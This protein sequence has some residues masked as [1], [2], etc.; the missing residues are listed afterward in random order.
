LSKDRW[1]RPG[2]YSSAGQKRDESGV[3]ASSIQTTAPES[4]R[5]NS[6]LVSAMMMPRS[7]AYAAAAA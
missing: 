3:S 2:S 7:S 6:N 5:P 4:S 1:G